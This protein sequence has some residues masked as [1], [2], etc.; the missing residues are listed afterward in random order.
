MDDEGTPIIYFDN[1]FQTASGPDLV[2]VL[3]ISKDVLGNTSPPAYALQEG[4]YV[5]ISPLKANQG[6]QKYSIPAAIIFENYN[7]IAIWCRTF[8]ATF[9]S[10]ALRFDD[11]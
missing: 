10:A 5:E 4:E 9:G 11:K 8:N 7:S 1:E 2:V 3:H 6:E